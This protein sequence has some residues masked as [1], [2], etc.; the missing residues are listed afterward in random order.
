MAYIQ[1]QLFSLIHHPSKNG[2]KAQI[3]CKTGTVHRRSPLLG[4]FCPTTWLS[5]SFPSSGFTKGPPGDLCQV[6]KPAH[7]LYEGCPIYLKWFG[8]NVCMW[9]KAE[10]GN[11]KYIYCNMKRNYFNGRIGFLFLSIL[12][13]STV[14]KFSTPNVYYL[15]KCIREKQRENCTKRKPRVIKR[16]LGLHLEI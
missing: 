3:V 13:P 7:S 11:W 4:K 6:N 2:C 1:N 12:Y 9:R 14:R 5:A 16:I 10:G 15:Y 8:L